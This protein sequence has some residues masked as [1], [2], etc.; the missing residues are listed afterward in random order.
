M[1]GQRKRSREGLAWEWPHPEDEVVPGVKWGRPEWVP[2]PAFWK[3]LAKL[4]HPTKDS[5]ISEPGTPLIS[6]VAFCLLGGYGIRME[7]NRAAFQLLQS[8]GCFQTGN[9]PHTN[10][11]ERLLRRPLNVEGKLIRYR[12]PRQ[13][14]ER[15]SG[16]IRM[17]EEMSFP[18]YDFREFR[19]A[20]MIIP[21]IGPKTASW[22]TRNWLGSNDVAILDIHI[23]RGCKM[24]GLFRGNI[25][26]PQDYERLEELFLEFARNIDVPAS[27]LDAIMWREMRVLG[28]HFS[29]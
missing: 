24:M 18:I 16:A 2:S 14:A 8:E 20:L 9:R 7:V 19:R 26:L 17:I 25:R 4:S 21:G 3:A 12:F 10:D 28:A 22:I 11:I 13:R 23:L 1:F 6:E 15:L 27:L 29:R 5:F